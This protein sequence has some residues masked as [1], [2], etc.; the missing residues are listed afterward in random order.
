[1]RNQ[2][3]GIIRFES[4]LDSERDEFQADSAEAA[5]AIRKLIPMHAL[6]AALCEQRM[7]D[8]KAKAAAY[9][10]TIRL[11]QE[12][13]SQQ[14]V[15]AA[16]L[17]F[18]RRV[19]TDKERLPPTASSVAAAGREMKKCL[20]VQER[21]LKAEDKLRR[22]VLLATE[23]KDAEETPAATEAR[24]KKLE[25]QLTRAHFGSWFSRRWK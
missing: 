2:P 16:S 25:K 15:A 24:A 18:L 22:M 13:I 5:D 4:D 3:K 14:A 12:I 1:M 20:K 8:F 19:V 9:E 21:I 7:R 10:K 11:T 6:T 17:E 23:G